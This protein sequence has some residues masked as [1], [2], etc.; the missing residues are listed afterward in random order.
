MPAALTPPVTQRYA[1]A[2][3]GASEIA[4]AAPG[5]TWMPAWRA[6]LAKRFVPASEM[7]AVTLLATANAQ[8]LENDDTSTV[9][10]EA[11]TA[12]SAAARMETRFV[13]FDPLTTNGPAFVSESVPPAQS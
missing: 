3:P 4:T 12:Q 11:T 10:F 7:F 13:P 2:A 1:V 8:Q 5:G 9:R 6:P